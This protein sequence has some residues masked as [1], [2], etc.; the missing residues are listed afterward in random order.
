MGDLI[1]L[2]HISPTELLNMSLKRIDWLY[3]LMYRTSKRL[4]PENKNGK[5]I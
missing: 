1:H 5:N 2:Y 3:A 4:N